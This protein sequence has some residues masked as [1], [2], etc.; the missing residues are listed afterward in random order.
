MARERTARVPTWRLVARL[1]ATRPGQTALVGFVCA[2]AA[3]A[4]IVAHEASRRGFE[5][6]KTTA[7][8]RHGQVSVV[9]A[10]RE[11]DAPLVP[12]Y[13]LVAGHRRT[14]SRQGLPPQPALWITSR[15]E[16]AA[17]EIAD[18]IGLEL[19]RR[20][21]ADA[22]SSDGRIHRLVGVT[23]GDPALAA[24]EGAAAQRLPVPE[25]LRI[26]IRIAEG[27]PV[28]W[29][30]LAPDAVLGAG[31]D[32]VVWV[33][34]RR[35]ERMI[36]PESYTGLG[37]TPVATH[38]VASTP[39]SNPFAVAYDFSQLLADAGHPLAARAWPELVGVARYTGA[40]GGIGVIRPL[41]LLVAAISVA[42]AV[43]VAARNRVRDV[44]LLRTIGMDTARIRGLYAR[45]TAA[46]S[47]A[48]ALVVTAAVLVAR[49]LGA[50]IELDAT[51]RRTLAA[52]AVLPP[53]IAFLMLRRVLGSPLARVRREAGL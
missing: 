29:R 26:A 47:V 8:L 15:V 19:H 25:G 53:L 37:S 32:G 24:G 11:P 6:L 2:I 17:R 27:D 5:S 41:A 10:D 39:A 44:V 20:I 50:D 48:A 7:S 35:L 43:A 3:A 12:R 14:D 42:G 34:L 22:V 51:V 52:T 1:V 38:L 16:E 23:P 4:G 9:V 18:S 28:G 30:E 40:G 36:V 45:E 33:R 21:E 13:P 46:A 31:T 49:A